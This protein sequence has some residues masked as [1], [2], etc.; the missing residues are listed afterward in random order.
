MSQSN[1]ALN[2]YYKFIENLERFDV[3]S[4]AD[5]AVLNRIKDVEQ[6]DDQSSSNIPVSI[7]G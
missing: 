5:R 4:D 6:R 3:R 2:N 7:F 1:N